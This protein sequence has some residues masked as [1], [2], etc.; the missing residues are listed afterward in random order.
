MHA[1][2]GSSEPIGCDRFGASRN[3]GASIHVAGRAINSANAAGVANSGST[4]KHFLVRRAG[5][6]AGRAREQHIDA[7]LL[8][9]KQMGLAEQV[10]SD[11]WQL[12][13]DFRT[14]LMA[15]QRTTDRQKMLAAHGALLSDERL[16]LVVLDM[17][18]LKTLEGRVLAHGE[19]EVGKSA[20]RHYLLLE[21]TDAN[22]H[23][24]Y[25]TPEME[26][27]RSRG[28]LRPNSFVRLQ[29]QFENGRPV[30]EI[31]DSG[32]AE[33]A[34]CNKRHFGDRAKSLLNHGIAPS[35][36]GWGGWLERY[37]AAMIKAV[38]ELKTLHVGRKSGRGR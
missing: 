1:A 33:R 37:Q 32:D 17:R 10:G 36:D 34:L 35:A 30:L 19:E 27:A 3:S 26:E 7:R 25:Y 29:K 24:I 11:E 12:R 5:E 8:V 15:M 22:V 9:L 31:E 13:R 6:T 14:V 38:D 28:M 21:G 23:L 16:P 4:A 20:G 18:K 2:T